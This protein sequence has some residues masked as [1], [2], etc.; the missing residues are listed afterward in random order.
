M[1]YVEISETPLAPGRSPV[2]LYYREVGRGAPLLVLH[3]G[4]GYE[5]Y[6]FHHQIAALADTHRILI[7]DRTGYGKSPR[8]AGFP[9]GFHEAAAFEAERFLDALDIERCAI[10]G[11][12]D[13]AV[14]AVRMALRAPERYTKLVLEALH[15]DHV[16][17]SS[18]GFFE[19]M[20][21]EPDGFGERVT[22]RLAAEHGD[23]WR[24]VI[25]ADGR[26]WLEVAE[27]E[28]LY[29][30]QLPELRVRTLV[31]HGDRDPRTEPD[32]LDRLRRD[33]AHADIRMIPGAGHSPHSERA[34]AALVTEIASAFLAA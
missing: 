23:D 31:V 8:V 29:D 6:P 32:E 26:V 18:R 25:S 2:E 21:S 13:G 9:S 28:D 30:G 15:V 20:A 19:M 10:W 1:P 24:T 34:S 16:K 33:V 27:G 7:P 11:H 22:T 12:S 4:W 5:F 14:I 17:P 3:G